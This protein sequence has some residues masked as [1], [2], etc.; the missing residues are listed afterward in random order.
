[1]MRVMEF[2]ARQNGWNCI[3]SDTTDNLASA[4]NFIKAGYRLYQPHHRASR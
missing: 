4:N 2:R 1:M 3:V